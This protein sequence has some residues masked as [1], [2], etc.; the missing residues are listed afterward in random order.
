M[1]KKISKKFS[2]IGENIK[3][4]R[5]A[6]K[7]SQAELAVI[8]DV[9]RPSVG[10]Y[11]EGRSEP[12]T[13]TII[14]IAN[15]FSISIDALLTKQLTVA[16]IYSFDRLNK[17]LDSVHDKK[18]PSSNKNA[19]VVVRANVQLDYIIRHKDADF[20]MS[21]ETIPSPTKLTAGRVFEMKGSDMENDGHG[22]NSGDL[23]FCSKQDF[24]KISDPKGEVVMVVT[25]DEVYCKRIVK[26]EKGQIQL[27]SDVKS[28]STITKNLD[29]ISELWRVEG[30]YSENIEPPSH[31]EDRMN[32]LE[33]L[34]KK[35]GK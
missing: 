33:E 30:Y 24:K 18:V 32:Q 25:S 3:K 20:I 19:L 4:I 1:A 21:L 11:E 26:I 2:F 7:I 22:I 8:L 34:V 5:Q 31:L 9:G 23:L 13:E 12:K 29:E 15:K 28:V 6:K 16:E 35:L 10:A 17:K 14:Q 27:C